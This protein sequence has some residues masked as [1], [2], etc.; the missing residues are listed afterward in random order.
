MKL[1]RRICFCV[2]L[3]V[4]LLAGFLAALYPR[5]ASGSGITKANFDLIVEG[6]TQVDVEEIFGCP[7]GDYT[8]GQA[9]SFRCGVGVV[10]IRKDIWTGYGGDI[11]VNF[12]KED[13]KVVDKFFMET[14]LWP[15]PTWLDRIK[16]LFR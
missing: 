15:K 16:R 4:I 5:P 10:G 13:G 6:M 3:A 1:L 14:A 8:N 12:R 2:P 11:E 9:F 7:P